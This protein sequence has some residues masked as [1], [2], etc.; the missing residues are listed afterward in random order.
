MA[1]LDGELLYA[2]DKIDLILPRNDTTKLRLRWQLPG[3]L[4]VL[5]SSGREVAATAL[6][7]AAIIR[8]EPR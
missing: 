5:D 8:Q 3:R 2:V 7:T 6:G 4:Q 1:C